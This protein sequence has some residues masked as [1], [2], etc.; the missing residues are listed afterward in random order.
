VL[1]GLH[2]LV[3]TEKIT[4]E[5]AADAP[6]E[7]RDF[8]TRYIAETGIQTNEVQRCWMLL[9]CFLEIARRT[10]AE[11]FDLVEIGSSAGLNLEWDRYRYLYRAGTW[12][13]HEARLELAGE[14]R[15]PFPA[16]LL[17]LAPRVRSRVGID[18]NPID[19]SSDDGAMLLKS[20]VWPDQTWRL[21]LLDRAIASLRKDPP[22][23][24]RGDIADVLPRVLGE[25]RRDSVTLVWQTAVLHYLSNSCTTQWRRPVRMKASWRS[26]KP[27]RRSP[28]TESTSASRFRC[29][30]TGNAKKLRTRTSTAP[31]SSGSREYDELAF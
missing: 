6:A 7:H 26:S 31:G 2:F 28:T 21:D 25:R 3:L 18:L 29:G 10:E 1:A 17:G 27:S 23:L 24:V 19:A 4:W 30:P 13:P 8:L 11:T 22:N 5:E 15:R 16:A 12:G 20:F 9:P 14:E